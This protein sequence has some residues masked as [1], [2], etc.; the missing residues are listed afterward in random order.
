MGRAS[1]LP[2]RASTAFTTTGERES[3]PLP[4][5]PSG[6]SAGDGRA[7]P[8]SAMGRMPRKWPGGGASDSEAETRQGGSE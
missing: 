6:S 3:I 1:P 5:E 4:A 7:I 2:L 8:D